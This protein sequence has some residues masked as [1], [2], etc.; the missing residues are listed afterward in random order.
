MFPGFSTMTNNTAI[1]PQSP[2]TTIPIT[3]RHAII[4]NSSSNYRNI[5]KCQT[6][7]MRSLQDEILNDNQQWKEFQLILQQK[8]AKME[9]QMQ[10]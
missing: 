9:S 6:R 10:H 3:S 8:V 4:Q 7:Q 1:A 5:R 2:K